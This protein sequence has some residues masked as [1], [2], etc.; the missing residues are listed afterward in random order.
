M[1]LT[2]VKK[3]RIWTFICLL[4]VSTS[5]LTFSFSA[6]SQ[7]WYEAD[8]KSIINISFIRNKIE[9]KNQHLSYFNESI[10]EVDSVSFA[11]NTQTF[12]SQNFSYI[13]GWE[14]GIGLSSETQSEVIDDE[15]TGQTYQYDAQ[16]FYNLSISYNLMFTYETDNTAYFFAGPSALVIMTSFSEKAVNTNTGKIE[17][18]EAHQPMGFGFGTRIG[19]GVFI[20]PTFKVD[21]SL[22][23]YLSAFRGAL[24]G[25]PSHYRNSSPTGSQQ[26]SGQDFYEDVDLTMYRLSFNYYF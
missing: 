23:E 16:W 26:R 22:T 13:Y 19:V 12:I 8:D 9:D 10:S 6:Q 15:G 20:S 21:I 2:N 14:F 1:V 24:S 18:G 11:I 3:T 25:T 5:I 17:Y 4:I 7:D